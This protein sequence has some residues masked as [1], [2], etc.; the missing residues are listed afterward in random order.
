MT[1]KKKHILRVLLIVV[2]VGVYLFFFIRN[3][4]LHK[5]SEGDVSTIDK[6]RVYRFKDVQGP[7][8]LS[9][10]PERHAT[11]W[12]R[13]QY[14]GHYGIGILLTDTNSAWLGLVHGFK[15]MGIPFSLY[16]SADSALAH[17]VVMVYPLVSGKVMRP[18]DLKKLAD[19]PAHG[20][21]LIGVNVL[22]G[23]N[24]EFGIGGATASRQ[25]FR[26][27][28][29]DSGSPLLKEFTDAREK[30][31]SLG[32]ARDFKQTVGTYAYQ[33]PLTSPLLS[34]ETGEACL[35]Q[36]HYK[37]GGKAFALGIDL[38]EFILRSQNERGY[39]A[40]RSYVNSYEPSA[41]VLLRILKNIY[42]Q[43]DENAVF[44]GTVP[45]GKPLSLCLTH[46]ID[47]TRSIIN[48]RKYAEMEASKQVKA[49]YFIQ[50]KYIR[51]WNDDVFFNDTGV[52]CVNDVAARGMEIG[53][54]SVA[55]SHA[56][57]K[58]KMGTGHEMYPAYA[59]F[60]AGRDS[61]LNATILGELRVSK[62]LLEKLV[63]QAHVVSFRSGHLSYPFSLPQALA[64]TGYQYSS[65]VTAN[66]VLSHLPYQMMY[67][68]EYDEEMDLFEFP[69][70]I[71]DEELPRL[72]QRLDKALSLARQ[73]AGYGG[74]MNVLIH[75]D[76]LA[77]KLAFESA[78]IDSLKG[79]AW[80]GTLQEY[81]DW[82]RARNSVHMEVSVKN[83]HH[84]LTLYSAGPVSRLALEVPAHWHCLGTGPN[85]VQDGRKILVKHFDKK[86]SIEFSKSQP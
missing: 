13:Y 1:V 71:E 67:N 84:V 14:P 26:V 54:H 85:V 49:T 65:C 70:T 24:D 51:D 3:N 57:S 80:I 63:K 59:P 16:T 75:T 23:L 34:Y 7:E 40:Q 22:G 76:T 69:V 28:M 64:A 44:I 29:R 42:A 5:A 6:D 50:T 60:V 52:A 36:Y 68:R 8:G 58:F 12:R 81:A 4:F 30:E 79:K 18:G 53:S 15:S 45:D 74:F 83:G 38:G 9:V 43:C 20:G 41:D 77:Y 31:I 10:L 47:F 73:I 86:L 62:F 2:V 33:K 46:D 32:S 35:T 78:L 39:N 55:H 72:D 19:V 66:N 37:G 61:A 11:S 17:R 27:M 21:A 25:R 82:W 56:F 48:A